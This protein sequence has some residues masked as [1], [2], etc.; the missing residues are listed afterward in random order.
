MVNSEKLSAVRWIFI[1]RWIY[2]GVM[3]VQKLTD[4]VDKTDYRQTILVGSSISI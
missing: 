1:G 2:Q 4:M 3:G